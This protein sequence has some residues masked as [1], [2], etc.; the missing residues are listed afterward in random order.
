[1]PKI[2]IVDPASGIRFSLPVP[3][4]LFVNLFVRRTVVLTAIQGQ[5]RAL[6]DEQDRCSSAERSRIQLR[7]RQFEQL[8][9]VASGF[10]FAELRHTLTHISAYKGLTLV[11]VQAADGTVVLITL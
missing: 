4:R 2:R 7:L 3:Y 9:E 8:H 5:I 1:M 10:D 11:D 6:M